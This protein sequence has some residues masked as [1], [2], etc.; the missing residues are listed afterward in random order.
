MAD[1]TLPPETGE[2]TR[3]GLAWLAF[4]IAVLRLKRTAVNWVRPVPRLT[5]SLGDP[6]PH[7][8]AL[9]R[10]PL[11][12]SNG[13]ERDLEL[14]K[15]QNLRVAAKELDGLLIPAGHVFSFWR[16]VGKCRKGKGYVAGRQLQEGC[17]VPAI[18]GGI[19]QLSNALYD[20]ALQ[21][22]CNIV[23]RHQHTRVIPGSAA[24]QDR[25]ATVAWNHIDLRFAPAAEMR[26]RVRLTADELEVSL[27]SAEIPN[28]KPHRSP[29]SLRQAIDPS[30][31]S[32]GT[33]ERMECVLF[34]K[35]LTSGAELTAFLVDEVWPEFDS[36]LQRVRT[37]NDTL[38]TPISGR[39]AYAWTSEG[40]GGKR[41]AR[42]ATYRRAFRSRRLADQGAARQAA[43]LRSFEEL[44]AAFG[45]QL[46]PDVT[47]VVVTLDLLP[48]LWRGGHLGG[49]TFDVLMTRFPMAELQRRLD[50]ACERHPERKLLGDFRAPEYLVQ[51]ELEALVA[52]RS[53]ITPH[54]A[55]AAGDRRRLLLEW[56]MPSPI[57]WSQGRTIVFP[58]PTVARKGAYEVREAAKELGLQV[59]PLG[60]ELEGAAFWGDLSVQPAGDWLSEACAVVQPAVLEDRPRRL[61]RA[62]AS[63]CPV[64]ATEACGLPEGPLVTLVPEG[65]SG[66]IVAALTRLINPISPGSGAGW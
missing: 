8:V 44:A 49:R 60:S 12:T 50:R 20:V 26:L 5:H 58:G 64:I 18:G 13:S 10:S 36:Y 1:A 2:P 54:R 40:F 47:H 28:V 9:H 14:G 21:A 33:C 24:A 53:L 52:A 66:A 34:E 39:A 32:C 46:A 4:R 61:L 62:I 16:H 57:A 6:P 17:L 65:D 22:G 23:E 30:A 59:R 63:G 11:R 7:R 29:L 37:V 25:D 38:M 48:F 35:G 43:R 41:Y 42:L 15:I 31:H 56:E 27:W 19:C 55:I 3:V 51:S 45:A